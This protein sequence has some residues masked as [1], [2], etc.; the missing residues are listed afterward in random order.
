MVVLLVVG[1]V[2]FVMGFSQP[3][4]WLIGGVA[5]YGFLRYGNGVRGASGPEYEQYRE[6]REKRD[7]WDRKYRRQHRGRRITPDRPMDR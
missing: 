3:V 1:A 6:Q 2:L 7:R 4:W 5:L